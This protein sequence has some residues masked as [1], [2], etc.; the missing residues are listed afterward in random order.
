[1]ELSRRMLL[2]GIAPGALL[3]VAGCTSAQQAAITAT[4]NNFLA[5][6][7]TLVAAGCNVGAGF[8]PAIPSIE[9]VVNILYPGLGT[10]VAG[11]AGAINSVASALCSATST[12]PPAALSR[13][14]AASSPGT[15]VYVGTIT[16]NG[17]NGP[18]QVQV[19]G[20]K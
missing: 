4:Y 8:I 10:A 9:A 14:L 6:V 1:M 7:Q 12:T 16:V 17:P 13:R 11:V 18:A 2:T 15:P 19:T 3:A 20:Y 5:Q